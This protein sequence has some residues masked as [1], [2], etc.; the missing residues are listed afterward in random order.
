MC[1]LVNNTVK[2]PQRW[3]IYI[4]PITNV[5]K[6]IKPKTFKPPS[7]LIEFFPILTPKQKHSYLL[8]MDAHCHGNYT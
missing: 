8:F 6:L 1:P 2:K 5:Q 4:Q 3:R 7:Y